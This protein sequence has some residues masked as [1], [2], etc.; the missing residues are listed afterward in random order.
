MQLKKQWSVDEIR[1]K[2]LTDDRVLE[3]GVLRLYER[4]TEDERQ[5]GTTMHLNGRGFNQEDAMMGT[6]L[7]RL[8]AL[9]KRLRDLPKFR[10]WARRRIP[11][12]SAQLTR[13][14][15]GAK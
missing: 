4:Q 8:L 11:Y 9:G 12:Y 5:S 10:A 13:I 3:R 6:I 2:L 15:N 14:A 1:G 7:G